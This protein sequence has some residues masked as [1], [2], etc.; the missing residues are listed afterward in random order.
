MDT[1]FYLSVRTET[2]A[3][4]LGPYLSYHEAIL[5]ATDH[6]ERLLHLTRKVEGG[7]IQTISVEE[8]CLAPDGQLLLVAIRLTEEKH[9]RR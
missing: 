2:D 4:K 8:W 7:S 9:A 5:L 1:F 3:I 6:I